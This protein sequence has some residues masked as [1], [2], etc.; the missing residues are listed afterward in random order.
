MKISI[1][2][3]LHLF[4]AF[5]ANNFAQVIHTTHWY[6]GNN[7]GLDF[8]SGSPVPI[9][10][11]GMRTDEGSA[12]FSDE[13]GNL[14]FYSNGIAVSND[15]AGVWNRNHQLMPNGDLTDTTGYGTPMQSSIVVPV[16]GSTSNY[17]LFT[18]DGYENYS[19]ANYKGLCYT[20]IDMSLDNG[21]GD[22]TEKAI[23]IATTA[24]PFLCE[25][26]ALTKHA[27]GIDYWLVVH[28]SNYIN[29]NSNKFILFLI[30]ENGISA[31]MTQNI[32]M[33]DSPGM[34]STMQISSNGSK[35]AFNW[36]IFD[37]N[38]ATGV[39]SNP[40]QVGGSWGYREF[41]RNGRF[42]YVSSWSNG[43]YQFDLQ[44]SNIPASIY[45][46]S[47]YD[48][49]GQIQIGPDGKI[50]VAM[51]FINGAFQ[52]YLSV[53]HQPNLAGLASNFEM[54]AITLTNATS[55]LGLPNFI[56]Y[57]PPSTASI[58]DQSI[59][60]EIVVFPNPATDDVKVYFE[61]PNSVKV[62]SIAGKLIAEFEATTQLDLD[63]SNYSKG[64]YYLCINGTKTVRF[65]KE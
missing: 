62:F 20:I 18:L 43:L 21:L 54:N 55:I 51:D 24:T 4:V 64:M 28:E 27:N 37:F 29:Q 19:N 38:N 5:S 15:I 14:L 33:D 50:Y 58:A 63:V 56:D 46:V 52:P 16:P 2:L 1:Q 7:A 48:R 61:S 44:A 60:P 39:L 42:L 47:D 59:E 26:M 45:Q 8:S 40:I 41:S 9:G 30:S 31:P 53:I 13:N 25:Q 17:Y 57:I 12:S 35:L 23:P 32:G 11:S 49:F 34:Q 6:F 10:S 36:E 22:V 65:V 3:L